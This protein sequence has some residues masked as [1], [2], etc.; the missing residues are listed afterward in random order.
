MKT[1]MVQGN[2]NQ[3]KVMDKSVP[4]VK[5]LSK[6]LVK[7]VTRKLPRKLIGA[8]WLSEQFKATVS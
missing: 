6:E 8:S 5:E 2:R 7:K 1:M 3:V 4:V